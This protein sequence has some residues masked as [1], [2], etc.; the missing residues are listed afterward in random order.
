MAQAAKR[1]AN[2]CANR[3]IQRRPIGVI[4]LLAVAALV[5]APAACSVPASELAALSDLYFATGG[6]TSWIRTEGWSTLDE[7]SGA[8]SDPCGTLRDDAWFGVTCVADGNGGK[9]VVGLDLSLGQLGDL[10]NGLDGSLPESIGNLASVKVRNRA[11]RACV[12]ARAA[13]R[14]I[15][16]STQK[17]AP[18]HPL[19]FPPLTPTVHGR[20]CTSA[21]RCLCPRTT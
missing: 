18:A 1:R 4:T 10:G 12:R 2:M 19:K 15:H 9:R 13:H 14:S 17:Y 20:C 7:E 6:P 5:L 16:P 21:P 11:E 8:P 3:D